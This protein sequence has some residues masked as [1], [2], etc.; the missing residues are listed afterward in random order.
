MYDLEE[1]VLQDMLNKYVPYSNDCVCAVL[2]WSQTAEGY[3][4]D[5]FVKETPQRTSCYVNVCEL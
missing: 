4:T 2:S 3:C 5:A 1:Y